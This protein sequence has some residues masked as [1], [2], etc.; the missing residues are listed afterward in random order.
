M[1]LAGLHRRRH[2]LASA[3]SFTKSLLCFLVGWC[4]L[5]Y[6]TGQGYRPSTMIASDQ[7]DRCLRLCYPMGWYHQLDS[8]FRQSY[9]QGFI[10]R[11]GHRLGIMSTQ[12]NICALLLGKAQLGLQL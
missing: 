2:S 3:T 10:D 8:I 5:Y 1:L 11:W 12:T 9:R 7:I 4:S 6:A